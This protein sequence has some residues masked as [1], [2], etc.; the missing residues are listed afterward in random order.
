M[1]LEEILLDDKVVYSIS[2]NLYYIMDIIP[3]VRHMI[4]FFHKHPDHYLDVWN[5]TLLALSFS[6]KNLD[7]RLALL[8]HDIGKPF[9][10]KEGE[11]RHYEKHP[12]VSEQM[13]REILKRLGYDDD[14]VEHICYLVKNHDSPI[15]T[16]QIKDDYELATKLYKVQYCD[17]LAHHPDSLERRRAYL[18]KIKEKILAIR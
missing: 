2:D 1:K 5:H 6:D 4:G 10:Y 14:Y 11:V 9:C 16:K 18:N 3:E 13:S 17:M 8:L 15:T 7:I 12:L